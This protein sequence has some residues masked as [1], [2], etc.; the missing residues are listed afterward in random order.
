MSPSFSKAAR[1]VARVYED[2]LATPQYPMR[3]I[4]KIGLP[5]LGFLGL[6]NLPFLGHAVDLLRRQ[7]GETIDLM[8]FPD[9]DPATADD[10]TVKM[11]AHA[12]RE[13]EAVLVF[14]GA[15]P[16]AAGGPAFVAAARI[17][18]TRLVCGLPGCVA[19]N[20]LAA[21]AAPA[22][23]LEPEVLRSSRQGLRVTPCRLDRPED[24]IP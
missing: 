7:R 10:W 17:E 5:K 16:V 12:A 14:A 4:E 13:T 18:R 19:R 24:S 21:A 3:D 15:A 8:A 2:A 20:T 22:P 11:A 9:A 6:T 23:A 1:A